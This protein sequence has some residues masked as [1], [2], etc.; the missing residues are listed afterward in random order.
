MPLLE[1]A[2]EEREEDLDGKIRPGLGVLSVLVLDSKPEKKRDRKSSMNTHFLSQH[3][4]LKI[5]EPSRKCLG[6]MLIFLLE[7]ESLPETLAAFERFP[8][9]LPC[10]CS[11]ILSRNFGI[12]YTNLIL[13]SHTGS[14]K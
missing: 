7:S 11:A 2:G 8:L 6:Y 1:R 12:N 4:V 5:T 9:Q 10:F 3:Q 13:L 14:P